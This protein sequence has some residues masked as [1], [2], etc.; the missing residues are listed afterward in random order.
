MQALPQKT[1]EEGYR[2]EK[3]AMKFAIPRIWWEPMDHSSNC[4]FCLVG[5]SKCQTGKHASAITYSDIPSFIARVLLCP[6]LP[7]PT[8]AEREQLS[9]EESSKLESEGDIADPVYN[10]SSAAD[11]RNPY[12]PNQKDLND[13]IKDLGFTKSNTA[14]L[15]SRLKK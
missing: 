13:L 1:L 12:Y 9:S 14:L 11:E 7:I 5:P 2:G 15:T 8:P 6:E 10:I 3:R 4:Y